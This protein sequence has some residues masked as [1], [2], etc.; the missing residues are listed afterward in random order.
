MKKVSLLFILILM[1][2]MLFA[3]PFGLKMGMTLEEIKVKCGGKEP[4]YIGLGCFY[5]IEPMKKD[6]TFSTYEV[7]VD[8]N[9]GLFYILASTDVET[10]VKFEDKFHFIAR[11]LKGYYGNPSKIEEN[12]YKWHASKCEK[13]KK[14]RLNVISLYTFC[15]NFGNGVVFLAYKFDNFNKAKEVSDSPF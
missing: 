11:A 2:N 14:E 15:D 3:D 5:G 12:S 10:K 8:G 13:L 1:T 4:K 6:D 9:M 7:G